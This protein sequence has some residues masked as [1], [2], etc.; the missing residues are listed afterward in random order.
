MGAG[1]AASVKDSEREHHGRTAYA[2]TVL[3]DGVY[4]PG[5]IIFAV[6][7]VVLSGVAY[8]VTLGN[9]QTSSSPGLNRQSGNTAVRRAINNQTLKGSECSTEWSGAGRPANAT[10]R[11]GETPRSL[12]GRYL[13]VPQGVGH[14]VDGVPSDLL[15]ALD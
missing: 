6:G 5:K 10:G 13:G 11:R 15:Y 8:V 1:T 3:A 14:R 4:G 7:G 2:G 9:A 12:A